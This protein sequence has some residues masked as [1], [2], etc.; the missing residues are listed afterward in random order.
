MALWGKSKSAVNYGYGIMP[1]HPEL[2]FNPPYGWTGSNGYATRNARGSGYDTAALEGMGYD[3]AALDGMGVFDTIKEV[4][5][6]IGES[7]SNLLQ[8]LA[9]STGESVQTLLNNP[10]QLMNYANKYGPAAFQ[11]A[12]KIIDYIK[13]RRAAKAMEEDDDDEGE[14]SYNP[15]EEN[16]EDEEYTPPPPPPP[17]KKPVK[18]PKKPLG[19]KK[20]K[21][22]PENYEEILYG[23]A[24]K[25]GKRPRRRRGLL[26]RRRRTTISRRNR[27]RKRDLEA[28]W[29]LQQQNSQ[30]PFDDG[31]DYY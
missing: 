8:K 20:R 3:T 18:K 26:G 13:Q 29:R 28:L 17:R 7:G 4:M 6:G 5:S 31:E 21:R 23:E 16:A 15:Y 10:D 25:R 1:K 19:G 24:P 30:M 27:I 9:K 2:L 14:E 11:S 12:K 22:L